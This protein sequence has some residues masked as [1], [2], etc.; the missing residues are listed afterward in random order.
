MTKLVKK[1]ELKIPPMG[2]KNVRYCENCK[3]WH[4]LTDKCQNE[5][6]VVCNCTPEDHHHEAN[7]PVFLEQKKTYVIVKVRDRENFEDYVSKD[8]LKKVLL[9]PECKGK[10]EVMNPHFEECAKSEEDEGLYFGH[11]TCSAAHVFNRVCCNCRLGEHVSCQRCD[12][13]G[14]YINMKKLKELLK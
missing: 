3:K 13:N 5:Y 9:C 10:G 12:G 11:A 14:F 6:G 4:G 7:C 1:K 2:S 8:D